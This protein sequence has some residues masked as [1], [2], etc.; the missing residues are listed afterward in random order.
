MRVS[1]YWSR[2]RH[3]IINYWS[4]KIDRELLPINTVLLVSGILAI[5]QFGSLFFDA[6]QFPNILELIS[7]MFEVV[8]GTGN[9]QF[10]DNVPQTISRIVLSVIIAMMIGVPFGVSMGLY[11]DFEDFLLL[12]LLIFLAMPAIIW[13]FL[14]VLWFGLSS[15]FVPILAGVLSLLPYVIVNS[16]KG[17][18]D[19]DSRLLEMA[20][21]FDLSKFAVWRNVLF[22]HLLPYLF[23]TTRM[24]FSIGWRV[25]LIIE[26]FGAG[27][28]LGYVLNGMFQAQRN[29]L[30]LA[31][32]IPV[33]AFIVLIE[34]LLKR[35]E[36][37]KFDWRI[38]DDEGP[39]VVR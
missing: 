13:A 17:V 6:N 32:S 16:W 30:L 9:F 21:V 15:Y 7:A 22:P 14:G 1:E 29:D 4:S 18:E 19:V 12:Y 20:D 31:W 38:D 39:E 5:W 8:N 34:R 3:T 11:N 28:G 33:I 35:Y 27:S 37:T 2:P 25:M 24:V 26:V 36:E 10:W 23:S